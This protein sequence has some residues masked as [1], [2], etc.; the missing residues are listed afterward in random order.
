MLAIKYGFSFRVISSECDTRHNHFDSAGQRGLRTRI[1]IDQL[2]FFLYYC[3]YY[4]YYYY[5]YYFIF[6]SCAVRFA[7]VFTGS[8]SCCVGAARKV[9]SWL[10]AENN[11]MSFFQLFQ[12]CLE[13]GLGTIGEFSSEQLLHDSNLSREISHYVS[14]FQFAHKSFHRCVL[15][16]N[17]RMTYFD[18]IIFVLSLV[19]FILWCF[20]DYG[21]EVRK[22]ILVRHIHVI[23]ISIL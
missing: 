7:I 19:L 9:L 17:F 6:R 11:D 14:G 18:F 23:C 22:T 15:C 8:V 10:V 2:F 21:R 5:Y 3:Y 20:L 12:Y 1:K 4:Y 13:S 16:L